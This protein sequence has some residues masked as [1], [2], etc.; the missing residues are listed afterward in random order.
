MPNESILYNTRKRNNSY[1]QNETIWWTT[2]QALMI[3]FQ[4]TI[5]LVIFS[6][7]KK[8]LDLSIRNKLHLDLLRNL[9]QRYIGFV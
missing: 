6:Y 4:V 1:P 9:Q 5:P 2:S 3:K 7:K 8:N